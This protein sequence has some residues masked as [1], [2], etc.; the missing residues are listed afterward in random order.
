MEY[1]SEY[2]TVERICRDMYG[3]DGVKAYIEKM[4]N[5]T[6]REKMF[7]RNWYDKLKTL[8]HLKWLRNQI[9]HDNE[10]YEVTEQD[11]TDI[12]AFHT[13]LLIQQDPLALLYK[14]IENTK[15]KQQEFKL[16]QRS[17]QKTQQQ[18]VQYTSSNQQNDE[19]NNSKALTIFAAVAV[20]A[21][22]AVIV[23]FFL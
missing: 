11:L 5:C 16:Q 9:A 12:T 18:Q 22:I 20:V 7:V 13:E 14:E 23:F 21:V 15:K 3:E 10:V 6:N 1:F 17:I 4:E 8:K 19:G 2:K